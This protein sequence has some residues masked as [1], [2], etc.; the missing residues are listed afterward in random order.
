[1][2][3]ITSVT[4]YLKIIQ[5]VEF[6]NNLF[7][8]GHAVDSYVLKPGIYREINHG[9][10]LIDYEDQIYREVISKSPQEFAG[11]TTL[12]SLALLQH[13]DAPTRILDLTENALVALFF[14]VN[15]KHEEED[16]EVIAFDIPDNSVC[17]YNSDRITVLANIAKCDMYFHYSSELVAV[18]RNKITYL[19]SKKQNNSLPELQ[20]YNES[21][22]IF[23]NNTHKEI[24]EKF[25]ITDE[26]ELNNYQENLIY[27][28]KKFETKFEQLDDENF[29]T[30]EN[31]YLNMLIG[32]L[33]RGVIFSIEQ[34]NHKYFGK[35][36]HN[37][38]EDKNY[39]DGIIDPEHIS[40]T[41]AVRPKLDN[42]RI[43][44]QQGAFL[45][46]GVNEVPFPNFSE[47][48]PMAELNKEWI[49][50]S[51]KE[52]IIIDKDYKNSIIKE[53]EQLG[54]N[55]SVLFP[56]VDKVADFVRNKYQNKI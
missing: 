51:E 23:F 1:M 39:F 4:E 10:T 41:F 46:F 45:I 25:C 44:R 18:Y 37:I 34:C 50:K 55:Q 26:F 19:K 52:R 2:S 21:I 14:A 49:I 20:N 9:K 40:K 22:S 3:K 32:I 38:R 36:L 24:E 47:N 29:I 33:Q 27:L 12:E 5:E 11:K 53:L 54:I 30:F 15:S 42:P 17:H 16:G 8:R 56:E 7:F 31:K 43:I 6:K 48:K 28:R 35:L 13:Y